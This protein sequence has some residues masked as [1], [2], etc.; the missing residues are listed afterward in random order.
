MST[1]QRTT[2]PSTAG[3]TV[4]CLCAEWCGTCRD[5]RAVFE[6]TVAAS[7]AECV[8]RW[9]DIEDEADLVGNV[10]VDN[11]P[12]LLIGRGDEVLFFGTVTPQP[13]TLSRLLQAVSDGD[14]QVGSAVAT[15]DVQALL[16]RLNRRA[17]SV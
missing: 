12:T 13:S 15:P 5:Y 3:L 17:A 9:V 1:D 2:P 8:P 7:A 10:D 14:G 4:T 6:A 11:F 16:T